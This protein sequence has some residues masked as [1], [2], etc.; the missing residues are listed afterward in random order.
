ML[1]KYPASN[2]FEWRT[3]IRWWRSLW[4]FISKMTNL[5]ASSN[6]VFV[7]SESYKENWF[8]PCCICCVQDLWE[9]F[10]AVLTTTISSCLTGYRIPP[11]LDLRQLW[12]GL[13]T[14]LTFLWNIESITLPEWS[15]CAS[16]ATSG[17]SQ[18]MSQIAHP[19]HQ[20]NSIWRGGGVL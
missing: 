16:T 8:M 20:T 3:S 19:T 2:Y 4:M 13:T 18:P 6:K 14:K 9:G 10:L 7:D 15:S 17:Q 5:S 12:K 11:I 1:E